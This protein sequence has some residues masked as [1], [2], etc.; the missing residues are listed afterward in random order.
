[1]GA[2]RQV[3]K[4]LVLKECG[5]LRFM[6]KIMARFDK[7]FVADFSALDD[8]TAYFRKKPACMPKNG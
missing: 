3:N 6:M 4:V 7:N 8:V 1:V 5:R 2:P